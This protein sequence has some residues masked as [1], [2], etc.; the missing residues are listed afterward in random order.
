MQCLATKNNCYSSFWYFEIYFDIQ[1]TLNNRS[2]LATMLDTGLAAAPTTATVGLGRLVI[3]DRTVRDRWTRP[4]R[5]CWSST[6]RTP[7]PVRARRCRGCRC[8]ESRLRRRSREGSRDHCLSSGGRIPWLPGAGIR[9]SRTGRTHVFHSRGRGIILLKW[10]RLWSRSDLRRDSMISR[11]KS[12]LNESG[13]K[14]NLLLTNP[15]LLNCF[16]THA[17]LIKAQ[18]LDRQMRS[19]L[20]SWFC[21]G[22][23]S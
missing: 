1:L 15:T 10:H 3:R 5:S 2:M 12:P 8:R 11:E 16:Q 18:N 13:S 21:H 9:P 7:W 4:G 23:L 20:D 17:L 14:E 6:P 19:F 22:K